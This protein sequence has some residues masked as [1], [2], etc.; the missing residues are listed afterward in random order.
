ML[1]SRARVEAENEVVAF[2][3]CSA[4]FPCRLRQCECAPVRDSAH[5]A[6]G[7]EHNVAGGLG[8]SDEVLGN[9]CREWLEEADSLISLTLRPGRT[10]DY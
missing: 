5:Y 2:I 9:G 1:C 4:L 6:A 10:C 3:I 7:C 8:D